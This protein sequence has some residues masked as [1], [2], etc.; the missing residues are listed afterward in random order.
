MDDLAKCIFFGI[1]FGLILVLGLAVLAVISLDA[2]TRCLS[3]L[4]L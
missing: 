1:A 2:V 3:Y 4:A